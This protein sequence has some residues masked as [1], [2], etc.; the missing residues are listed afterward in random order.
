MGLDA[1][2]YKNIKHL[3]LGSDEGAARIIPNTGEVY[4]DNDILSRKYEGQR[5]AAEHRVGN[6]AEVSALREE[7]MRLAGPA[8]IILQTVLYSGTHSGDFVPV[9]SM[10]TLSLELNLI[11]SAA[12]SPGL[13]RF[14]GSLETLIGAAE[15]EGNPIVFV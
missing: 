14:A 12:T 3:D 8:S 4:F 15:N 13:Q 2:V 9:N 5:H 10:R 1:V 11:K 6:I 7:V